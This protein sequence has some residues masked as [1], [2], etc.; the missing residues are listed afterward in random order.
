MKKIV[1]MCGSLV[2]TGWPAG[3]GMSSLLFPAAIK[4]YSLTISMFLSLFGVVAFEEG[5]ER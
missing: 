1:V 5:G 3:Q 4:A 2:V